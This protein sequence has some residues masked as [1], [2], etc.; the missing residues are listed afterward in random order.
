M[1]GCGAGLTLNLETPIDAVEPYLDQVDDVMLMSIRPGWSGQT[2][3]PDVYAR[4]EGVRELI[5]RGGHQ[6]ELEVDGGVKLDNAKRVVEAG[7]TVLVSAS[8]IFRE[9][10]PADAARRLAEIAR[11]AA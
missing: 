1:R 11:G 3:N 5:D 9:P 2:L 8:G 6:V 10:D 7:A 4:V